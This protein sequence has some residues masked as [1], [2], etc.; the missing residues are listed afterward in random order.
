MISR[1]VYFFLFLSCFFL[2]AEPNPLDVRDVWHFFK[3]NSFPNASIVVN[4]NLE[5]L[6][7]FRNLSAVKCSGLFGEQKKNYKCSVPDLSFRNFSANY[8]II[9]KDKIYINQN[10][11]VEIKLEKADNSNSEEFKPLKLQL[12]PV[13]ILIFIVACILINAICLPL[14][15]SFY[16]KR[17]FKN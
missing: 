9:C 5:R 11:F 13:V 1:F 14:L 17:L 10:C 4:G 12:S 7:E 3:N 15:Y 2:S 6:K 8:T 16:K